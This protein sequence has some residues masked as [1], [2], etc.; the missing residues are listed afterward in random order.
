MP[1]EHIDAI[2]HKYQKKTH[3]NVCW[4]LCRFWP[5]IY[6]SEYSLEGSWH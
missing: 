5:C 2:I 4:N 1:I 3:E 6:C